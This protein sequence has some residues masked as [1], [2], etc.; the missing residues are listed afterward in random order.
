MPRY[1][2]IAEC[3]RRLIALADAIERGVIDERML[4]AV[5]VLDNIFPTID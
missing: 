1:S 2:W 4:A 3:A 5:E